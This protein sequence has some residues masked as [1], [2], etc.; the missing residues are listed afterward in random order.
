MFWQIISSSGNVHVHTLYNLL[1]CS[2]SVRRSLNI[3]L[4]SEPSLNGRQS[5]KQNNGTQVHERIMG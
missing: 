5:G 4:V 2:E 1:P 3:P